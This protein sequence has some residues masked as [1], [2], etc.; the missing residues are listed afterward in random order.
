[1]Q[2]NYKTLATIIVSLSAIMSTTQTN[3]LTTE[4]KASAVVFSKSSCTKLAH[5]TQPFILVLSN[6]EDL[7]GSIT[8]CAKDAKLKSATFSGLGQV[9][10]PTLAYFTSNPNDKPTL[11]TFS[12]YYELASFNGDITNNNN[13]YYSHA[14]AVL[15]D[16]KFHGIAGHVNKAKVGLTAEIAITPLPVPV[17]RAVDNKTG[18]GPIIE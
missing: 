14:H 13:E 16:K 10:N 9:H 4:T 12:G 7:L 15:A 3:A 5:T 1:M 18:F 2:P 17:Q 6:A 8:Q 11:T